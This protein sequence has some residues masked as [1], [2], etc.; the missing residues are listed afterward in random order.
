MRTYGPQDEAPLDA[1]V[2]DLGFEFI[3]T[4]G[5]SQSVSATNSDEHHMAELVDDVH[6]IADMTDATG[7]DAETNEVETDSSDDDGEGDWHDQYD[8]AEPS[9]ITDSHALDM[10]SMADRSLEH[11]TELFPRASLS[12]EHLEHHQDEA[13]QDQGANQHL[14]D[15]KTEMHRGGLSGPAKKKKKKTTT[16]FGWVFDRRESL[17]L[18]ILGASV[19]LFSCFIY[20]FWAPYY[21]GCEL[22][23][24]PVAAVSSLGPQ[25][26]A[27]TLVATS[28]VPTILTSTSTATL[29]ALQTTNLENS[30]PFPFGKEKAATIESEPI[31]IF[32]S[33]EAHGRNEILLKVPQR[34]KSAW[35]ARQAILISLSRGGQDISPGSTKVSSVDQGFIIE[36]P[37]KEAHGILDVA[38]ATTKKPKINETFQVN[39][40]THI[41]GDAFDSGKEFMRDFMQTLVANVDDTAAWAEGACI[42][43]FET[44]SGRFSAEVPTVPDLMQRIKEVAAA[45]A[46][47]VVNAKK[48]LEQ[49]SASVRFHQAEAELRRL[50]LDA[51]DRL[52]LRVLEAQLSSKLWWL[53]MRGQAE[54]RQRYLAAA[55]SYYREKAEAASRA[56][57]SR[58]EMMKKEIKVQR[59]PG[60][61]QAR[62]LF[63]QRGE[64]GR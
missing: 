31:V 11:P 43:A 3:G 38:I 61:R 55:E 19:Q 52:R 57:Q 10:E 12:A 59:G 34:I 32:C 20:W 22:S 21:Q 23:T 1:S 15:I 64:E 35:L 14:A 44:V 30:L 49:E 36:V 42:Q 4:D 54:E 58:A 27:E 50:T 17:K 60:W 40:G 39:F 37:L 53:K 18:F 41:L 46:S 16:T 29:N 26:L 33:A 28:T 24:V 9:T 48:F 6:S 7:T 47:M 8:T 13:V 25:T 63:R 56:S 62:R 2:D 45:R 51:G 5:E